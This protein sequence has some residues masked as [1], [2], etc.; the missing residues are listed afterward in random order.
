[1]KY[2]ITQFT[3]RGARRVNEDR[4]GYAE[5]DNAVLMAVAD[6]LGGHRGGDIAAEIL[7]QTLLHSFQTLRHPVVQRPSV[8]LA[9]GILQA[10]HAI[11]ARGQ[12]S[13]PPIEPRTTCVACLVQNGYAYWAHVGDSRLY[14]FRQNR[15]LLRTQDHTTIEELHQGGL[16][17]EKEMLEHPQKSHLLNCL[18]AATKPTISMSEETLLQPGDVLLA[19]T[20]GLW[21]ALAPEEIER[22]MG[23]KALDEAVEEMLYSAVRK[24]RHGCDNVSAVCLRWEDAITKNPPLQGNAAAQINEAMLRDEARHHLPH[25]TRLPPRKSSAPA[26]VTDDDR[27]KPLES[28]IQEIEDFLKKFE[29]K[30]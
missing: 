1:M 2:S 24:K 6:G 19:C 28:R 23:A 3:L 26:E 18:G 7:V 30:V 27:K 10:H 5:R 20:D 12:D 4:I 11:V 25:V 9:L 22:Y 15:F 14:L 13:Q 21:E 29:P 8:F 17:T 16:L